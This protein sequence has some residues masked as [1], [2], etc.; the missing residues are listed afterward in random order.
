[1]W[2]ENDLGLKIRALSNLFERR[3]NTIILSNGV[4]DITP[5]HGM[6]L[7]YL[8]CQKE[9]DIY[10][11]DIETQFH[12]TRSTVTNILQLM[13]KK[14]YIRRESVAHDA[15]LKRIF[16]TE[17]GEDSLLR[18]HSSIREMET[19]LRS[20]VTPEEYTELSCLLEKIRAVL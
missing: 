13:E 10:Q 20:A 16:L 11:R 17:K 14:G 8:N 2:P 15:R 19:L 4:Q 5:M 6:I 18:I 12:I 9:H 3:I 1:M 7:G